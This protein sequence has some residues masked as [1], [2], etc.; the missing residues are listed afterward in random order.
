[1]GLAQKQMPKAAKSEHPD[2]WIAFVIGTLKDHF[3]EYS[4]ECF[5]APSRAG[6]GGLGEGE[7]SIL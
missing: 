5:D 1:M 4:N 2:R 3:N 7:G 6:G